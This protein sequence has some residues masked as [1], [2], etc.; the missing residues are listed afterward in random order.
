VK[1]GQ[2]FRN[3]LG[4]KVGIALIERDA[5]QLGGMR[6]SRQRAKQAIA[7]SSAFPDEG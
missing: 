2:V 5:A 7:R 3:P 1:Y 4:R 6:A